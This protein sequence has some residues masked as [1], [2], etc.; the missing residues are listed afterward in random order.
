[1]PE[2]SAFL[3]FYSQAKSSQLKGPDGIRRIFHSLFSSLK[4]LPSRFPYHHVVTLS[5][6][7]TFIFDLHKTKEMNST[8]AVC[9]PF[10]NVLVNEINVG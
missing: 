2:A 9:S 10:R 3:T 1:M 4:P 7:F 6:V 8:K 5:T